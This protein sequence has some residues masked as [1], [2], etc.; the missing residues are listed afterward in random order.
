MH[1]RE[2][3]TP[4]L[5]IDLDI[6]ERNL[7]RMAEYCRKIGVNLRPHTKTHKMLELAAMQVDRGAIGLTVAKVGEA[8]IMASSG[9]KQILVA[10]PIFGEEKLHRLAQTARDVDVLVAVDDEATATAISQA[11]VAFGRTIGILVEFDAG[12]RRCGLPPGA[13][14]VQLARTIEKLP[15]VQM[16]GLMTY[17]GNVWGSVEERKRE[18]EKVALCV[19]QAVGAFQEIG[20]PLEIVSGGSTPAAEFSH[21][22]SGLTEIRPGTYVFNDMNTY[23]QGACRLDDCAAR[24]VTTVIST[25]VSG[26]AVIDAG[27]KTLSQDASS[28]GPKTGS[29]YIVEAPEV[30]LFRLNE[31]HGYLR[32]ETSSRQF[33]IGDVLTVIPNHVCTCINLHDEVFLTRNEQVVGSWKV[34]ARGKTR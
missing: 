20:M 17:F 19:E 16:R 33:K 4:A 31:E 13:A 32:T 22:I 21:A 30:P 12:F 23:Y 28:A 3:S 25:A 29:G 24:V 1:F 7:D 2:L 34:A 10:H 9:S 14:C 6:V 27:S 8:E 18:I 5:V 15:G 11:A 26:Q